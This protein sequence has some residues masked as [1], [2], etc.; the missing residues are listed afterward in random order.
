[1]RS[2]VGRVYPL[3]TGVESG[4]GAVALPQRQCFDFS[5]NNAG[6]Y[7]GFDVKITSENVHRF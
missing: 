6:F 1:M 7:P 3:P 2:G 4:E 5:S